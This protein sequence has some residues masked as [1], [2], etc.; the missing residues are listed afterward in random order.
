MQAP[1]LN[2]TR[3]VA[4]ASAQILPHAQWSPR[5]EDSVAAANGVVRLRVPNASAAM[6]FL[7]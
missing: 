6:L 2:A 1:A 4:L 5:D 3:D 7:K